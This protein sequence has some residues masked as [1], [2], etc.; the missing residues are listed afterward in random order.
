VGGK[1]QP[2]GP[3]ERAPA[4][5]PAYRL[6]ALGFSTLV[7]I[8]IPVAVWVYRASGPGVDFVSFWAA[9]ELALSGRAALAYDIEAHRAVELTVTL[10]GGL[11]PFPYPPPFLLLVSPLG[12]LPYWLAYVP[13]ILL[14]GAVYLLATRKIVLARFALAHPGAL[15][16]AMIGQNGF[17]TAGLFISAVT[18][19]SSRPLLAGA[20]AGAL[21]IKPQLALLIPI[22]F[23]AA[24]NWR[25]L[26]AG[27][28]AALVLVAISAAVFGMET[29]R[30]FA[31]MIQQQGTFLSTREWNWAEQASIF[32]F[33]RHF[34]ADQALA[35]SVQALFGLGAAVLVW[36]AWAHGHEHREA[37]LASA[38]LLATPYLFIYDTLILTIA[39]A[40]L[41]KDSGR[42]WLLPLVWLCLLVP[43]L[44]FVGVYSGP[45]TVP[46]GA[47]LCLWASTS[48]GGERGEPADRA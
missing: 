24:R 9:A 38:T 30:A 18:L 39:I 22:A 47:A 3:K 12:L 13:W 16:N 31:A 44:G 36:R 17:L 48:P 35:F 6:F 27:A 19:A 15:I 41:L 2:A 7:L 10:L 14:T 1:S 25:A 5:G 20:L 45:N 28:G 37:V 8:A 29:W 23:L 21:V 42:P 40:V 46:I 32:A 33:L 43:L 26:A 11:M 34:E 4:D